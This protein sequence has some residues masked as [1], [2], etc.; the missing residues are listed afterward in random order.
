M[1]DEFSKKKPEHPRI[2]G[3]IIFVRRTEMCVGLSPS[4]PLVF[5]EKSLEVDEVLETLRA[6]QAA[7]FVLLAGV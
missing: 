5:L 4:L 7:S 2:L 6:Q 1:N 3:Y